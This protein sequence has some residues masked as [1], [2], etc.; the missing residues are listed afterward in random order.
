[1]SLLNKEILKNNIDQSILKQALQETMDRWPPSFHFGRKITKYL[2]DAPLVYNQSLEMKARAL[3]KL[4]NIKK[5]D[6]LNI[7]LLIDKCNRWRNKKKTNVRI[8]VGVTASYGANSYKRTE[9]VITFIDETSVNDMFR[10][11]CSVNHKYTDAALSLMK[12]YN[13]KIID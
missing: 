9:I 2:W 3:V 11:F 1:M 6:C 5:E 12:E 7:P 4:L 13:N 10:I 8:T